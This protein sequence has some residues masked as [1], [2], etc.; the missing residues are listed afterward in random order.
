[1]KYQFDDLL[2]KVQEYSNLMV[3]EGL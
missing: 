3:E 2:K 1:M